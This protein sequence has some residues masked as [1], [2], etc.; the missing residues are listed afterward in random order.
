MVEGVENSGFRLQRCARSLVFWGS[1]RN[2]VGEKGINVRPAFNI[3]TL[4]V[5]IVDQNHHVHVAEA[6]HLYTGMSN[7]KI[8]VYPCSMRSTLPLQDSLPGCRG[9]GNSCGQAQT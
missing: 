8:V 1:G 7:Q 6:V 2:C 9:G 3:T 4:S 5:P